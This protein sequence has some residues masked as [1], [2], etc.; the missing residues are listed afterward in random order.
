MY[1]PCPHKFM[2]MDQSLLSFLPLL[3]GDWEGVCQQFNKRPHL[4]PPLRGEESTKNILPKLSSI[5]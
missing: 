5:L 1:I 3:G 2:R 4:N